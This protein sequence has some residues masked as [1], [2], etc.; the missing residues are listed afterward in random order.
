MTKGMTPLA[1]W[2]ALFVTLLQLATASAQ[3]RPN[4]AP[5]SPRFVFRTGELADRVQSDPALGPVLRD[6]VTRALTNHG[7]ATTPNDGLA[8]T[9]HARPRHVRTYS[10]DGGL[11]RLQRTATPE[12]ERI[13]AEVNLVLIAEPVHALV[14]MA[15]GAASAQIPHGVTDPAALRRYETMIISAA[16]NSALRDLESNLE[17]SPI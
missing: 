9:S 5:T 6:A 15:S 17:R 13:R 10:I 2:L 14:G 7:M 8:A 4:T 16:V 11:D 3:A 12:G 1:S